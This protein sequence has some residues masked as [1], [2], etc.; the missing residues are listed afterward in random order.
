MIHEMIPTTRHG[1]VTFHADGRID[2]TDAS[3]LIDH[4]L[5]GLPIN[6]ANADC[7]QNGEVAI[8]DVARLIDYLLTSAW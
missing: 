4:L 5:A 6:E 1:D 7:D 2:I 8:G 3:L